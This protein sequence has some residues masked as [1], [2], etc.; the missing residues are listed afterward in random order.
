MK[1]DYK[2]GSVKISVPPTLLIS[3][4]GKIPDIRKAVTMDVKC[5]GDWVYVVGITKNELG[6]SEYA[7]M[8]NMAGGVAPRVNAEAAKAIYRKIFEAISQE[9]IASC[10][11]C[12]EGGLCVALIE[13]AFAGGYGMT[14]DL[15][16]VPLEG[17]NND[18]VLMFSESASRFVVTVNP[19][20]AKDFEKI[21][22]NTPLGR[23][24]VVN[25]GTHFS[26]T[27][28]NGETIIEEDIDALKACWQGPLKNF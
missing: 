16:T 24:G 19:E 5:P 3:A 6:G 20:K 28:I 7:Q 10:H 11:D 25:D 17:V 14:L 8:K 1:N 15:H 22:G 27:G 12:S 18:T 26:V 2:A 4:I 13:S 21:M 9:L 23:I